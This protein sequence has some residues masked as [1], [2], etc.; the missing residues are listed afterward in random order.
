MVTMQLL[1]I[2]GNA[3]QKLYKNAKRLLL[4]IC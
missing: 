4:N 1:K 3:N 2:S